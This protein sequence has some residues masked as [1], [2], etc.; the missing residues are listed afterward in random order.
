MGAMHS[1][2]IGDGNG[3]YDGGEGGAP[4][5]PEVREVRGVREVRSSIAVSSSSYSPQV[6]ALDFVYMTHCSLWNYEG[7]KYVYTYLCL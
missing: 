7:E 2:S 4:G 1:M 5:P 6:S 3:P